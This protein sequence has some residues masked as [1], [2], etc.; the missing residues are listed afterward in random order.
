MDLFGEKESIE[1][2][3]EVERITLGSLKL[4]AEQSISFFLS[5]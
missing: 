2:A 5:F 4:F 1:N 3:S